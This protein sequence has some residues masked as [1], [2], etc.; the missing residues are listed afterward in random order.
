MKVPQLYI[1]RHLPAVFC[2]SIGVALLAIAA[3]VALG[4]N[5]SEAAREMSTRE[6]A[7]AVQLALII[8]NGHYPDDTEP[9]H[10]AI[11]DANGL[12]NAM[13]RHGFDVDLV[14][15]ATKADMAR[16]VERLKSRIK[17][18]SVVMLF[19]GGYGVQSRHETYMIP[20]DAVIW[21]ERDVRHEGM[22]VEVVLDAIK[23]RGARTTL[24]VLDASRRNPYERRFRSY[25]HGLAPINAP[26][27][28]LIISSDTPGKV[29]YD[30][31]GEHSLFVNELLNELNAQ[32][33]AQ[34]VF[35]RTRVAVFR[36]SNGEQM[37]S[38]SSSLLEDVRF[39][40]GND[41]D[42]TTSSLAPVSTE[43]APLGA[44]KESHLAESD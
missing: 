20:T 35:N 26:N 21:K 22:S 6:T 12:A 4:L 11:N 8:G 25:S 19:F 37:P 24:A 41:E 31:K 13:R 33:S 36:A 10:Q 3:N 42:L 32:V 14:E 7:G 38:V 43:N 18:G 40:S 30:T 39:G 29:A 15:D 17:P 1:V 16:A 2:S 27:N 23:E 9:L 28:S 5:T 34:G 44:Q